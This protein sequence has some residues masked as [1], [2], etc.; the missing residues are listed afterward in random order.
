M[1]RRGGKK[2]KGC[3]IGCLVFIALWVVVTVIGAIVGPGRMRQTQETAAL[4]DIQNIQTAATKYQTQFGR[5]PES[6]DELGTH[7]DRLSAGL[8]GGAKGG[9]Q[10]TLQGGPAVYTLNANPLASN[11]I[12]RRTFYTDQ[13]QVV[14]ENE[15]PAPASEASSV[16]SSARH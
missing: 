11:V 16:A 10:F 12:A 15:G 14:R 6:L 3:L 7:S 9:Y 4:K 5:Y 1:R 13:T 2:N 8:A